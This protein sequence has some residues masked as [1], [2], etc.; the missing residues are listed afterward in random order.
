MNTNSVLRSVVLALSVA[1][2]S[3][4]ATSGPSTATSTGTPGPT[5]VATPGVATVTLAAA[6]D[7]TA[8]LTSIGAIVGTPTGFA[9]VGSTTSEDPTFSLEIGSAD[10]SRWQRL[11]A[12]PLGGL[13]GVAAGPRGWVGLSQHSANPGGAGLTTTI[14]YSA[15][16]LAWSEVP[17]QAGIGVSFPGP[18]TS[19]AGGAGFA[20]V[21]QY[22]DAGTSYPT[23]WTSIDGTHWNEA[24]GLRQIGIDRVLVLNKGFIATASG[25]S[26]STASAFAS[27]DGVSWTAIVSQPFDATN[28]SAGSIA[29]M[30]GFD[31]RLATLIVGPTTGAIAVWTATPEVVNGTL[32]VPWQAHPEA[33][34]AFDSAGISGGSMGASAAVVLGYDRVTLQPLAWTSS[35]LVSWQRTDLDEAT[36]DGGARDSVAAGPSGF[37]AL[38]LAANLSGDLQ[39]KIW[40][41]VDG[42][43]WQLADGDPLGSLPADPSGPC[44]EPPADVLGFLAM[45]PALWPT[46][47]G[48]RTL[49]VTG[50][51]ADC[52]GCGGASA[53]TGEPSWLISP[54]GY[55]A[56]WLNPA[57]IQ[58]DTG[59]GGFG[60]DI[61]PAHP[62]SVPPV[63]TH[64][65]LT[66][67][68]DDPAASTCRL[69]PN[70]GYIGG[71]LPP[72][73]AIARCRKEFVVTAIRIL[74]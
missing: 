56:F 46:C 15:D 13:A 3:S 10:G 19:S 72:A 67:H 11:D 52:G 62:V 37:V 5:P 47:F 66:G 23:V 29:A 26:G 31:S 58:A 8:S 28:S 73:W 36:F 39:T 27:A 44:P 41:S 16:G 6:T 20:V 17:D 60:V 45:A 57:F 64:V 68:F 48:D 9:M 55:S 43:A 54:L 53:E 51:V 49:T 7:V 4:A 63:N 74:G 34:S 24:D 38:G 71:L 69:V 12:S 1:A 59:Y 33:T 32:T 65:A 50:Y 2:C 35:D 61:D 25:A 40:H 18:V 42:T 30:V 22:D 14:W 70:A 21:G